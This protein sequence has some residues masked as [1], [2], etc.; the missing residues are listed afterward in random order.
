[1]SE[2]PGGNEP[3]V[4]VGAGLAGY[5]TARE[6][7]K[8]DRARPLVIVTADDGAFYSKPML[9]NALA[10][11]K[12]PADLAL[13]DAG[14]MAAE[15]DAEILT[16]TRVAA[17]DPAAR[18]VTTDGGRTLAYGDLVLATG[19]VPIHVPLEGDAAGAVISV[20]HL[21]DYARFREALPGGGTVLIMGPGLIGCEF[22]N[23]LA[24]AGH[25][26]HV[27]GPAPHPLDR[28]LPGPAV[29]RLQRALAEL[30]VVWHLGTTVATLDRAGGRL[31]ATLAN[32]E[33][34][35]AD[36]VLSAVGLAP[37]TRLAEAAGLAVN[38]GIAVDRYLRSSDP[39][40][41]ALGDCAEV[42]GLVLPFVMPLMAC[43]R[44][45]G[46]TLAGTPTAVRYPPMP[47]TVKTPVCP[48]VVCPPVPP[49]EGTWEV[50]E[51]DDGVRGLYRDGHGHL[52][53]FA[54]TEGR[55]REKQALVKE[56]P[57]WLE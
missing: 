29:R 36:V 46:A 54:L 4:I 25:P 48:V 32:D 45:L 11:H 47:V 49:V 3:V 24:A 39:H 40:V 6:L 57:P 26:V 13:K 10:Q 23:D 43:A 33:S 18:T 38:R 51:D 8:H 21:D 50:D 55:V 9:S 28:L 30:G 22:A 2:H 17:I 14:A 35:T 16:R 15:L 27:V 34:V 44:A 52:R 7:R 1:M 20:N 53:G 31:R 42:E 41:F 12:A 56:V 37:D 19:A 5:T